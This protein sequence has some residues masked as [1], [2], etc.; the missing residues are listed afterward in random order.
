MPA[1]I[2]K[3][4]HLRTSRPTPS[5]T[6]GD[7]HGHNANFSSWKF[8][9]INAA[10]IDTDLTDTAR[11]VLVELVQHANQETRLIFPTEERLAILL[12]I[13]VRSVRRAVALLKE[14]GWIAVERTARASRTFTE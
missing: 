11:R 3:N 2:I 9:V 7:Q 13:D 4:G 8:D 6:G 14:K 10:N 12:S 1:G 5:E